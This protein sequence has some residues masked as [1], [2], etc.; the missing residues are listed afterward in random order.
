MV[1]WSKSWDGTWESLD[2]VGTQRFVL[3]EPMNE[4]Q[5]CKIK[6]PQLFHW[7][8]PVTFWH[9]SSQRE[10]ILSTLFIPTSKYLIY[11][12]FLFHPYCCVDFS[13]LLVWSLKVDDVVQSGPNFNWRRVLEAT[14]LSWAELRAQGTTKAKWTV[15]SQSSRA[16]RV[17]KVIE[18]TSLQKQEIYHINP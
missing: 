3:E 17:P 12:P 1:W 10:S 7:L 15:R 5:V 18:P 2:L 8:H 11:G 14:F 9:G 16:E 4:G 6:S 13:C